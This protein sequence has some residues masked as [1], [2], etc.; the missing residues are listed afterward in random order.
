MNE[1][2]REAAPD[3]ANQGADVRAGLG[4]G[5]PLALLGM[6]I[7]GT[8]VTLVS[9]V[10]WVEAIANHLGGLGIVGLLACLAAYIAGKKGRDPLKAF[11]WSSLLPIA[12]GVVAVV[13]VYVGTGFVYCG[14]GVILL[15]A[16]LFI[17]GYACLPK[18][19]IAHA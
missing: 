13:L 3:S 5:L 6:A 7:V 4:R 14:G 11:L 12:L 8:V 19:R 16:V 9:D 17:A 2:L 15:S 10:R 1:S 18:R